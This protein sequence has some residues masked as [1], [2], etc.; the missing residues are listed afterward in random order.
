MSIESGLL[1]E[2]TW[3][4]NVGR[5]DRRCV[6]NARLHAEVKIMA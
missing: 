3:I 1:D 2:T 4:L 5:F 6:D